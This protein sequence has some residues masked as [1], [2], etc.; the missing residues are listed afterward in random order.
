M[1]TVTII[2]SRS[3]SSEVLFE[4]IYFVLRGQPFR[5]QTGGHSVAEAAAA[6]VAKYGWEARELKPAYAKH[7]HYMQAISERNQALIKT[8]DRVLALWDGK[9]KGTASEIALAKRYGKPLQLVRIG[10]TK[11][12]QGVLF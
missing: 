9:S 3:I 5:L 7:S 11:Q 4:Q 2:A 10:A 1:Q 8:A 12:A 6:Y